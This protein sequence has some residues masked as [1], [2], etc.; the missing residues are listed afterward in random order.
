M[1]PEYG[2]QAPLQLPAATGLPGKPV[3]Q[4]NAY[5]R[6]AELLVRTQAQRAVGAVVSLSSIYCPLGLNMKAV[7]CTLRMLHVG[8]IARSRITTAN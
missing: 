2:R 1:V 4:A 3:W 6:S 8:S 7:R 5:F